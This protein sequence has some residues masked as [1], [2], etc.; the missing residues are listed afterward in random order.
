MSSGTPEAPRG[1][2]IADRRFP[3]PW[4]ETR[5]KIPP[6]QIRDLQLSIVGHGDK[7]DPRYL[8]ETIHFTQKS[9][10][11]GR[12]TI[13]ADVPTIMTLVKYVAQ[14]RPNSH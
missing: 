4:L 9:N 11:G 10:I 3:S 1:R 7:S 2:R 13:R 12:I 8:N 6:Q 5:T 14:K